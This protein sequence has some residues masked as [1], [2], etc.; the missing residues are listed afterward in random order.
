MK[1]KAVVQTKLEDIILELLKI[2][3]NMAKDD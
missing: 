1:A 2:I 3:K